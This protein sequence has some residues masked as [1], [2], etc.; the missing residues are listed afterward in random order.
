MPLKDLDGIQ[1]ESMAAQHRQKKKLPLG[2]YLMTCLLSGGKFKLEK[3]LELSGNFFNIN[4]YGTQKILEL[5]EF[6]VSKKPIIL[7]VFK[8]TAI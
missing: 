7:L 8:W 1:A 4:R 3:N 6:I 5:L 2:V